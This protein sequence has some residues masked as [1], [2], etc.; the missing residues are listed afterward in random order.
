MR[1]LS[2]YILSTGAYKDLEHPVLLT[3]GELGIYYVNTEKLVCDDGEWTKFGDD[4]QKMIDHAVKQMN[5]KKEFKAV[6]E[7][8]AEEAEQIFSESTYKK[9]AISGGQRRDWL[10]SGPVAKLLGHTHISL[11]KDGKTP[12]ALDDLDG[13]YV[14]H[15]VDLITEGSSIFNIQEGREH[16]WVPMLRKRKARIDELLS[17]VTR[18]QGGEERLKEQG[19]DVTAF[20]T[21]DEDFVRKYSKY[22]DRAVAYMRDP[23]KWNAEF[24]KQ[25]GALMFVDYFDP[26]KSNVKRAQNFLWR[27][28]ET[29]K[30]LGKYDELVKEIETRFGKA[31]W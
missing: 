28:G 30:E 2:S 12:H 13:F 16:G 22:P 5:T 4:H 7:A 17:V 26:T 29:L 15:V 24:L 18:R 31:L 20:V 19:V 8:L 11:Y 6:I 25:N 14:V 21:I 27:Y 10:F 3:S 9:F 1:D 23:H